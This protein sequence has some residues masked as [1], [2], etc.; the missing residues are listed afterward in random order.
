MSG[1]GVQISGPR[2]SLNLLHSLDESNQQLKKGTLVEM[3]ELNKI[4]RLKQLYI[5]IH[6]LIM[7]SD[8]VDPIKLFDFCVL[9][10]SHYFSFWKVH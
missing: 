9:P 2:H 4:F 3:V 10:I 7:G 1:A 6:S 5:I 8:L